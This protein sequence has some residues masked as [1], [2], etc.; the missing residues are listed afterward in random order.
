MEITR[1]C[2][3]S[4]LSR[5]VMVNL[6]KFSPAISEDESHYCLPTVLWAAGCIKQLTLLFIQQSDDTVSK[7]SAVVKIDL[8][9]HFLKSMLTNEP[10]KFLNCTLYCLWGAQKKGWYWCCIY[11]HINTLILDPGRA[12]KT[13]ATHKSNI[14][15]NDFFCAHHQQ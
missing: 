12:R 8:L 9:V 7:L 10:W 3:T 4:A 13:L 15:I 6:F 11:E 14:S 5:F 1:L 2:F